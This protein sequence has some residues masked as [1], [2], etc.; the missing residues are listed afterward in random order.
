VASAFDI[1]GSGARALAEALRRLG[2]GDGLDELLEVPLG[3]YGTFYY[4]PASL[5]SNGGPDTNSDLFRWVPTIS[6]PLLI[7]HAS[8]DAFSPFQRPELAQQSA[9]RSPR[10]DLA[11]LEGGNHLFSGRAGEVTDILDGWLHRALA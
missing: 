1:Q 2:D 8:R 9:V 7:V 10:A 6:L 4:T 3:A 5:V 11:Y